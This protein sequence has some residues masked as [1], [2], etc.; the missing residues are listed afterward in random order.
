MTS[1]PGD[2]NLILETRGLS[3]VFGNLN[4]LKNGG[5]LTYG[6]FTFTNKYGTFTG[7]STPDSRQFAIEIE[8]DR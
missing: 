8:F 7:Y 5:T 4:G 1:R 3:K 6:W 2:T